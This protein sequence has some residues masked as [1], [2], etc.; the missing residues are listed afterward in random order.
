MI[1]NSDNSVEDMV[2]SLNLESTAREAIAADPVLKIVR[3]LG[4]LKLASIRGGRLKSWTK[5]DVYIRIP[6]EPR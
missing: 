3:K 1:F 5:G 2:L 4:G 6:V